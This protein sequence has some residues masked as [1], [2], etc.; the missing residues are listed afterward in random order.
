MTQ[1]RDDFAPV[2]PIPVGTWWDEP[3]ADHVEGAPFVEHSAEVAAPPS[4]APPPG[5]PAPRVSVIIPTLNEAANLPHVLPQLP[6]VHEV[7]IVDGRSTDG[8]A[9]VARALIPDVRVVHQTGKGK[10]EA[11]RAGLEAATGD[12]V[13]MMDADGSTDPN[14]IPRF[15][16]ALVSGAQYAKGS[17]FM[18]GGGTSDMTLIR[19]LG[20][21]G[22]LA[23]VR[24]LHGARFTDLCYG[25]NAFWRRFGPQLQLDSDGFEIETLMNIRALRA[26][27]KVAEV[28]SFEKD[29]INGESHLRSVPDGL[30]VLRTII[31][32]RFRPAPGRSSVGSRTVDESGGS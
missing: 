28:P 7:I 8:T 17:R 4:I 6:S 15:V 14:E 1:L 32:E 9:D 22:L 20:N 21:F 12:I 24:V 25:Y 23:L 10:G 30:R 19:R 27:L 3:S 5:P 26:G 18:E 29:R 13:V 11:L 16:Q 2:H 31:Q